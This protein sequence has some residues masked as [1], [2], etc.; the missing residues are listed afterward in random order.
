[1]KSLISY[2]TKFTGLAMTPAFVLT[3]CSTP[4]NLAAFAS[5]LASRLSRCGPGRFLLA[6][7]NSLNFS[8]PSCP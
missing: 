2:L 5:F 4:L 3:A 7:A 1:M 6:I 8:S